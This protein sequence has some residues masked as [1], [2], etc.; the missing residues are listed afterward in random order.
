MKTIE[1]IAQFIPMIILFL[2]LKYSNEFVNFSFTV[3]GK[4]MAVFIIIFYANIDITVGICVCG[5]VI[6]YYQSDYVE[7]MLNIGE[8]L[9]IDE[10]PTIDL[11]DIEIST[12]FDINDVNTIEHDG[13][14]LLPVDKNR[15]TTFTKE[16]KRR[17]RKE[18]G[19]RKGL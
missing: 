10:L 9:T 19:K 15:K 17:E 6:L 3:L 13:I 14:Y 12:S 18:R 11:D 4:L 2:L 1:I 5:L 16:S 8:I 7:N